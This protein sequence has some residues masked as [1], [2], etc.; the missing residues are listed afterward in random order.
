MFPL[1]I[2]FLLCFYFFRYL[3]CLATIK[4][5]TH[6]YT[7]C[8]SLMFFQTDSYCVDGSERVVEYL[9]SQTKILAK[10]YATLTGLTG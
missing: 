8:R 7:K 1:C 2:V 6:T 4:I 3:A 10:L 9:S 5:Y